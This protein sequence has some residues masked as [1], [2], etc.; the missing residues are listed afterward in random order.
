MDKSNILH[1]ERL[2]I[3]IKIMLFKFLSDVSGPV[4]VKLKTLS[5]L[6]NYCDSRIAQFIIN[7]NL[8]SFQIKSYTNNSSLHFL[9]KFYK[10]S[11][12]LG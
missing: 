4:L 12:K 10:M 6:G 7:A 9:A 5:M 3:Y 1:F 2:C 8:V 11:P